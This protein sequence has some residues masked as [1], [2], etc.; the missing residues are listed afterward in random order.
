MRWTNLAIDAMEHFKIWCA[1]ACVWRKA[2][3]SAHAKTNFFCHFRSLT[4]FMAR[5][6]LSTF[7]HKIRS[8]FRTWDHFV[9][10]ITDYHYLTNLSCRNSVTSF[11]FNLSDQYFT[12]DVFNC[13]SFYLSIY[14][15]Q[16]VIIVTFWK[17]GLLN[18]VIVLQS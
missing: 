10:T 2:K 5:Y 13:L 18:W 3:A 6:K 16:Q 12:I 8:G 15:F 7:S 11:N 1:T 17:W 4:T 9:A 14:L